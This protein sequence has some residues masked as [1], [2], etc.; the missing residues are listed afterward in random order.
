MVGA[1][2]WSTVSRPRVA[3]ALHDGLGHEELLE[4]QLILGPWSRCVEAFVLLRGELIYGFVV[5]RELIEKV[6]T[7]IAFVGAS[8][9]AP[10]KPVQTNFARS[11]ALDERERTTALRCNLSNR[12][13]HCLGSKRGI[14]DYRAPRVDDHFGPT[15]ELVIDPLSGP[16]RIRARPNLAAQRFGRA[17]AH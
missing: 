13:S 2:D 3:R 1:P 5:L 11:N 14:D 16:L 8:A 10:P 6:G 4:A 12:A 17:F 15:Q 7:R 9:F